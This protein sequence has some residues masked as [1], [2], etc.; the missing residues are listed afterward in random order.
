MGRIPC[1]HPPNPPQPATLHVHQSPIIHIGFDLGVPEP[2][3]CG[4]ATLWVEGVAD[5]WVCRKLN[6]WMAALVEDG[7]LGRYEAIARGKFRRGAPH[8]I[9]DRA[10]LSVERMMH[11]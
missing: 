3:G 11:G 1:F 5:V 7:R 4:G 10:L 8:K 6:N 9:V 2:G